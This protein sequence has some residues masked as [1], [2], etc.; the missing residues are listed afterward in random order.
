MLS[1]EG[2]ATEIKRNQIPDFEH[3]GVMKIDENRDGVQILLLILGVK[4]YYPHY[5]HEEV[6]IRR[7]DLRIHSW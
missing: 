3:F 1:T 4:C 7:S 6:E 2:G 5:P